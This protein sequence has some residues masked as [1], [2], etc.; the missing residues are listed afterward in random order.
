[1]KQ[2]QGKT[3]SDSSKNG[4]K[5]CKVESVFSIVDRGQMVLP[6]DIRDSA[7]IQA[8]NEFT[9]ISSEKDGQVYC[10][11]LMRVEQLADS[12][13]NVLIPLLRDFDDKP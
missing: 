6:K 10:I 1:M 3:G 4:E 9:V 7:H 13:R 11:S 12:L 8:G 5:C 2:K